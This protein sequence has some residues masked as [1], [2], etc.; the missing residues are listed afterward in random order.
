MEILNGKVTDAEI[1]NQTLMSHGA[2]KLRRGSITKKCH[3][4][5]YR[6]FLVV[7]N[8]RYKITFKIKYIIPLT[9]LWIGDCV[10]TDFV[11]SN[12]ARKSILLGWPME[13][14]I[15]TFW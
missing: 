2:V 12:Q 13:N 14:F 6:D 4:Y 15:A 7:T 8:S 11:G 1:K 10:V 3:L 9:S 5:L